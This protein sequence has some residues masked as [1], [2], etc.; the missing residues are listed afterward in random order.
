VDPQTGQLQIATDP[1]PQI[2]QGIP[3]QLRTVNMTINRPGFIF[4]P[5]NCSQLTITGTLTS[6]QG[7]SAV[8]SSR[9]RAANCASLKFKPRFSAVT[10]ARTSHANGASLTVKLSYPNDPQGSEANVKSV[11]VDLPKQLPSRLTTLQQ[12]CPSVQFESN[13]ASCP[14]ESVIGTAKAITPVLPVPLEGPAYFVSHGGEAFPSLIF[15]LQGDGVTVEV[16]GTT[17]INHKGITSVTFR[18]VPDAPLSSF[19]LKLPKGPFSALGTNKNLC[20]QK[21]VMPTAITGQNGAQIHQSTQVS[22][23]GCPKVKKHTRHKRARHAKKQKRDLVPP[24]T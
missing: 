12:A 2:L 19:E 8:V 4:N 16:A 17:F 22:V 7:A 6:A 1:L 23:A 21:L 15:V 20:K 11:K 5:T 24:R 18:R 14:A 10:Q 13:P 9:F 3:L